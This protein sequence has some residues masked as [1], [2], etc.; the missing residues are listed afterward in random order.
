M[1]N[2]NDFSVLQN[3]L[4]WL[5]GRGVAAGTTGYDAPLMGFLTAWKSHQGHCQC[6]CPVFLTNTYRWILM[7]FL[8]SVTKTS[9]VSGLRGIRV[10][11]GEGRQRTMALA[12][13]AYS[14]HGSRAD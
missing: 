7:I 12:R 13:G 1:G 9:G 4:K 11:N 6:Y 2:A 8:R 14:W 3:K 10:L 5:F